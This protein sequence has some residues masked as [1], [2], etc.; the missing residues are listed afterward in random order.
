L[1][2][3]SYRMLS[4]PLAA[5]GFEPVAWRYAKVFEAF[6]VIQQA[7]LSQ[8]DSLDIRWKLS[9]ASAFPDRCRFGIAKANDQ[10]RHYN[11]ERYTLQCGRELYAQDH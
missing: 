9:A 6:R 1:V 5:Q 3:H 11:A 4:L 7:E 2:V 8:R 10:I